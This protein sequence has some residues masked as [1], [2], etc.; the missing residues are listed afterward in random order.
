MALTFLTAQS[1]GGTQTVQEEAL[2]QISGLLEEPVELSAA[3]WLSALGTALRQQ[4]RMSAICGLAC[5]QLSEGVVIVHDLQHRA[6]Y[7]LQRQGAPATLSLQTEPPIPL[8]EAHGMPMPPSKDMALS[9][10]EIEDRVIGAPVI[11]S[12][13]ESALDVGCFDDCYGFDDPTDEVTVMIDRS[14]LS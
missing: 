14:V 2:W 10:F 13:P 11:L 8:N 4:G 12:R 5:E 9:A 1:V 6:R 3:D 7:V